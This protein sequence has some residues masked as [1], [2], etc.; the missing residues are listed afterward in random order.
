M[1]NSVGIV[2]YGAYIPRYR[3]TVE[4]IAKVWNQNPDVVRKSLAVN[5]KAVA[6]QD[7]DTITISVEAAKNAIAR[8]GIDAKKIGA[9]F[10][11]S[12][13][14]PYVVKP[15][16][17]VVAEA[18]NITSE[19]L[20]VDMEF[21]CKAGTTAMQICSALV[22]AGDIEYGLAVGAD[23]AQGRPGDA[24][25]YTAASGGAAFVIGREPLAVIEDF[26]SYATDTP[27]F[28]RREGEDYPKHGARFTGKPAY[29]QHTVSAARGL[30]KKLSLTADDFDYFVFH[31]P[32]GKFPREAAKALGFDLQ[33]LAPSMIVD[34]IGNA[35]SG[36]SLL[37]LCAV[38]D[39]AQPGQRILV[40]SFGSGAG[41]DAF[42]LVTTEKLLN[43]RDL[44]PKT[45]YYVNRKKYV[46]YG[47]YVKMRGKLKV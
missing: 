17:T 41:S 4:E 2:G 25:E 8:A 38:L 14:H 20:I 31:M 3:I 6:D 46:D 23:T 9:V 43:I 28:W 5:E 27:D 10:V 36:S 24:L 26:F 15:S 22:R 32:N 42:S 18:L 7:E 19:V 21:A 47:T 34:K 39:I 33:K 44:A 12:E 11:G 40:T 29:F 45:D 16:G 1:T 30:L 37:G 13:S 35:Y